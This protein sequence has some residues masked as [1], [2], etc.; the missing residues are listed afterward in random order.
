MHRVYE[1]FEVMP[2]GSPQRVTAVTGLEFAK[3][4][5][6]NLAKQTN[7]ECSVV[8]AKTRQVV[9]QMNVARAK[10][11]AT[12]RIF[13]I[14]YDEDM[15]LRRAELLR[16]RGYG[17][18]SVVGNQAAKL[19]LSS[20][21]HYGL[22]IVG[23]AA[24]E[25][26]RREIVDWLKDEYPK[27]KIL[28]LNPLNQQILRADYNVRQNGPENWLPIVAQL[29]VDSADSPASSNASSGS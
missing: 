8:D 23:H 11:R 19:L 4:A 7:N 15:G 1:I 14:A 27:V 20:I 18:I 3:V 16:S 5:I 25:E 12:T 17:V 6:E 21:Q 26:T 29:L 13:Q 28:A 22:F 9:I 2:N 10:L 24:P